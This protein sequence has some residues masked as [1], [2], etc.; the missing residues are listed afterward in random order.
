[1]TRRQR[2]RLAPWLLLA[3]VL[4]LWELACRGLGISDFIFPSPSRICERVS[5]M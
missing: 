3:V 1:M 2:E 4:L 5:S